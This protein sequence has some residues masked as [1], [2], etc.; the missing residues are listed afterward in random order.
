MG[1]YDSLTSLEQ[2]VFLNTIQFA[3]TFLLRLYS[4]HLILFPVQHPCDIEAQAFALGQRLAA[5]F[6]SSQILKR[7]GQQLRGRLIAH[8]LC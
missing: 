7:F 2:L 8:Q 5:L 6:L 1:A 3:A 4:H